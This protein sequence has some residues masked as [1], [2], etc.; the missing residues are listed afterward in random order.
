MISP[1]G[2]Q[3]N[4]SA[5]KKVFVIAEDGKDC[6]VNGMPGSV[7]QAGLADQVAGLDHIAEEILTK[8]GVK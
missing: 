6:V 4:L 1:A 8:V 3:K 2:G 7:V 5:K